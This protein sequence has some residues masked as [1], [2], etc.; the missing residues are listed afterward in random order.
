MQNILITG[1]SR[2]IGL[3]F[4]GRFA[5]RG[6]LVFATCRN[7]ENAKELQRLREKYPDRV[8]VVALDVS[9]QA[10][11]RSAGKEV[12]AIADRIDI[13]I[14]NAGVYMNR[15]GAPENSDRSSER[16]GHLEMENALSVLR[17]NSV[18]PILVAQEFLELLKAAKQSKVVSLTSGYGSIS[19]NTWGEPFHYSASKAALNMYMKSL[20]VSAKSMG[21]IAIVIDPGWVQ[22][23]MGGASASVSKSDSVSGMMRV[24]DSLTPKQTGSFF[25]YQGH[26]EGW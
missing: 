2:G 11:I 19:S 6:D 18:G 13:L 22:T 24:I 7:P 15:P 12:R 1:A 9:D 21:V 20:S 17:I 16:L 3:E 23:D 10:S 5:E 8:H 25:N 4:A 14:N 26:E